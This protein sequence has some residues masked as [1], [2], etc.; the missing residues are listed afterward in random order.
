MYQS[1]AEHIKFIPDYPESKLQ[2]DEAD[3]HSIKGIADSIWEA[4]R[5][6]TEAEDASFGIRQLADGFPWGSVCPSISMTLAWLPPRLTQ[7]DEDQ[8]ELNCLV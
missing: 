4:P 3:L 2:M 1:R 6:A 7:E 8:Y 5:D